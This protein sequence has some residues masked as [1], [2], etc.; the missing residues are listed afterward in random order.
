MG[1]CGQHTSGSPPEEL[2][3]SPPI[4]L[5]IA[6]AGSYSVCL[7]FLMVGMVGNLPKESARLLLIGVIP[8]RLS[9][10]DGVSFIKRDQ[11]ELL[12]RVLIFRRSIRN[13]QGRLS[14]FPPGE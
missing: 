9:R 1:S 11:P 14:R 7:P 6:V 2:A 5:V 12:N 8:L 3:A 10:S 13:V 4:P